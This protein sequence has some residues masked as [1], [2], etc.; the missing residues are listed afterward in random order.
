VTA[1]DDNDVVR[2]LQSLFDDIPL[3]DATPY[4]DARRGRVRLRRVRVL[5]T[6]AA[7]SAVLALVVGTAIA[8]TG[9]DRSGEPP[10]VETPTPTPT[11]TGRSVPPPTGAVNGIHVSGDLLLVDIAGCEFLVLHRGCPGDPDPLSSPGVTSSGPVTLW[12]YD[13]ATWRRV[14][15]SPIHLDHVAWTPDGAIGVARGLRAD[16]YSY[17]RDG[18]L[19]WGTAAG[20][21]D[22]PIPSCAP[23]PCP[24][25][26]LTAARVFYGPTG[27]AGEVYA[28]PL[29]T[30]DWRT[31]PRRELPA[32]DGGPVVEGMSIR[33]PAGRLQCEWDIFE[34][35]RAVVEL[36]GDLYAAMQHPFTRDGTPVPTSTADV[37]KWTF[38]LEVSTD[39]CRTWSR[40]E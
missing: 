38:D 17:T 8:V 16:Q 34:T 20:P 37:W 31:V 27:D 32:T 35:P 13:G 19:T 22:T 4:D 5:S 2:Q 18:G 30:A 40:V 9:G 11:P 36:D 15:R 21:V 3:P 33:T 10:P 29:G 12:T 6:S 39:D 7:A 1:L 26:A 25:L 24:D 14:G 23:D 28:A